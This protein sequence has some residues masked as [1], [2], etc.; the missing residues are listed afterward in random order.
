MA[1]VLAVIAGALFVIDKHVVL[2]G[3]G[4]LVLFILIRNRTLFSRRRLAGC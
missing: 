1:A 3:V 2:T 4:D